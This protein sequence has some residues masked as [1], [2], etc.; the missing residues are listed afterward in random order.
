MRRGRRLPGPERLIGLHTGIVGGLSNSIREAIRIGC[1]TWQIF[2]RNPRGWATRPLGIEEVAEFRRARAE[3]ALGPCLIHACYLINLATT[4]PELR[5][6]SIAAFREELERGLAIGADYLVVHPG[7]GGG[8]SREVAISNC[9]AGIASATSGIEDQLVRANFRIL[10]ENTAGQG[11]QIGRTFAEVAAILEGISDVPAGMCL[12]T[13]HAF[14]AGHDW[15]EVRTS[16]QAFS[17]I[18]ETVGLHNVHA[19]HF[20]DSKVPLGSGV[21]RHWHIGEG[22]IGSEGLRNVIN[23]PS[24]RTVPF[25]LETPRESELVDRTNL[26]ITFGLALA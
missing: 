10:I 11:N 18:D 16:H 1:T 3:S 19:V 25:I 5:R 8:L 24:L 20:N 4:D 13:A 26:D 14:A 7:S 21:D 9:I 22:L 12:D 6:K 2:S 17:T 15:R 23:H